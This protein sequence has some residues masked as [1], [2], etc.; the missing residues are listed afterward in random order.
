MPDPA[1][2]RIF[3]ALKVAPYTLDGFYP[4]REP[5][6][7]HWMV[8]VLVENGEPMPLDAIVR[9][10]TGL[11]VEANT[12][13][14]GY[15]L[16]KAWHGLKPVYRD[17]NGLFGLELDAGHVGYIV[18]ASGIIKEPERPAPPLTP[19]PTIPGSEQPIS[20]EEMEALCE[21]GV[22]T[23]ISTL[24]ATAGLLEALGRSLSIGEV[25]AWFGARLNYGTFPLR[26]HGIRA[27]R[28]DLVR[29][30]SDETLVLNPESEGV[31]AMRCAI[32]AYVHPALLRKAQRCEWATQQVARDEELA[33]QRR[34]QAE[35]AGTLRRAILHLAPSGLEPAVG[36]VLDV[37]ARTFTTFLA[38]QRPDARCFAG[39]DVL[40]GVDI[41]NALLA[42]GV[43]P[44]PFRLVD[45]GPPQKT[46]TLNK[47]GRKL[48]ITTE[49]LMKGSVGLSLGDPARLARYIQEGDDRHLAARLQADAKALHAYYN[50][51]RLHGY[52]R[53]RWGFIDESISAGWALPGEDSLHNILGQAEKEGRC[54]E[55]VVGSA[56]GWEDPWS[57]LQ[58]GVVSRSGQWGPYSVQVSGRIFSGE[59]IQAARLG[60]RVEG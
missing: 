33:T 37:E 20:E 57:R 36:V 47:A 12:G 21:G 50:Y 52:V 56:P 38:G 32:H 30:E 45:L 41:R 43:D 28:S 16:R 5:S 23:S 24:R 25:N 59:D 1:N 7:F 51:G 15:S 42:L 55:V 17:A 39:F 19:S 4:P 58:V 13:D 8:L 14:L 11:E 40:I 44:T 29:L 26:L 54:V 35:V 27:W 31:P 22:C 49:L 18:R 6:L 53:L 48:L 10:L 3:E 2:N 34:R 46:K 60:G 9:R